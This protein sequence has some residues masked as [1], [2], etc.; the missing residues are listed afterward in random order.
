MDVAQENFESLSYRELQKAAK[1]QG[2]NAGG[3]KHQILK[4]LQDAVAAQKDNA[5]PVKGNLEGKLSARS[6]EKQQSSGKENDT[7]AIQRKPTIMAYSGASPRLVKKALGQISLNSSRANLR[8]VASSHMH[9]PLFSPAVAPVAEATSTQDGPTSEATT[10]GTPMQ[11]SDNMIEDKNTL[12]VVE[13]FR[14]DD[15]DESTSAAAYAL[16]VESGEEG[17][18]AV[19]V[20]TDVMRGRPSMMVATANPRLQETFALPRG[21]VVHVR[22]FAEEIV[23]ELMHEEQVTAVAESARKEETEPQHDGGRPEIVQPPHQEQEDKKTGVVDAY[24]QGVVS[25]DR[26]AVPREPATARGEQQPVPPLLPDAEQ[27]KDG[28]QQCNQLQEREGEMAAPVSEDVRLDA[29]EQSAA[30]G[31]GPA[32]SVVQVQPAVTEERHVLEVEESAGGIIPAP[33]TAAVVVQKID[34]G[35]R[36][37]QDFSSPASLDLETTLTMV[38]PSQ[39]KEKEDH[40][41]VSSSQLRAEAVVVTEKS[42]EPTKKTVTPEHEAGVGHQCRE[43]KAA[44]S[45]GKAAAVVMPVHTGLVVD[46]ETRSLVEESKYLQFADDGRSVLCTL[47]GKKITPVFDNILLY[48]GSRKVQ[49]LMVEGPFVVTDYEGMFMVEDPAD[50]G[51]VF[52]E[53]TG[54]RLFKSKAAVDQHINSQSFKEMMAMLRA[55]LDV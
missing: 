11:A 44:P 15:R 4:R 35:E 17:E 45:E 25:S 47:T 30:A 55:R 40:A 34:A 39:K 8:L 36:L 38:W 26:M 6:L 9:K 2:L 46:A 49:R 53:L 48:M 12:T 16:A 32:M 42:R 24:T 27:D 20:A 7:H 3:K 54:V 50:D 29:A 14:T 13:E 52:C 23:P 28:Q 37:G 41:L 22:L 43:G 10:T 21:T 31:S 33:E 19:S 1:T 51:F 18:S 5:A